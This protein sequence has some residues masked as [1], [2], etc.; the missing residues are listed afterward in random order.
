[1]VLATKFGNE[2][3]EDGS[4]VGVNGRPEYVRRRIDASL[5]RLGMDHVDLYY[6]HRV[7]TSVPVE[8]TVGAMAGLVEAGK[9]RHLGLSGAAPETI[10]RAHAAHPISALQT[11][12]SCSPATPRTAPRPVRELGIGFVAYSPLGRG[13]LTGDLS[14]SPDLP[15]G[16]RLPADSPRFAGGQLRQEPG[17]GGQGR[18]SWRR[19]KGCT[20]GQLA[21]AWVL[22]PGDDV[23]P[24]PGTKRRTYLEENI[25]AVDIDL[26]ADEVPGS[27]T[28]SV[29]PP[30]TATQTWDR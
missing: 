30:A 13:F 21:L 23:V 1:M 7:D 16:G 11:E 25:A 22:G 5:G 27:R 24:I 29:S 9:V 17:A 10:R 28:M 2:R 4:Y 19:R 18:G 6:Q 26:G 14:S 12:Y 3:R 8:E 15:G 20:P